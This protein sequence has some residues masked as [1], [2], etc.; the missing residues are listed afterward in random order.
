M[1]MNFRRVDCV[2]GLSDFHATRVMFFAKGV[3]EKCFDARHTHLAVSFVSEP[4]SISAA[5]A[6]KKPQIGCTLEV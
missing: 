4:L 2:L 1:R 6:C 5:E 3:L